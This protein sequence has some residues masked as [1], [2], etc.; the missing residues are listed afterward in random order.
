[1]PVLSFFWGD[2][3]P[4][5]QP[6]HAA[7]L[8]VIHQVGAVDEAVQ[9]ANAGVDVVIAQG[10]EAGGHVAGQVS[11]FVLVPRIVDA[12][13]PVPVAAAG[14]IADARGLVAALGLGAQAVV[15]GTRFLATTESAA[16]PVYKQKGTT[17]H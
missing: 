1:M 16:H 4:Y 7:G 14:G 9:A 2:P 11:T 15:L 13:A 10:V 8:K 6:A 12:V 3:A 17:G 5:V